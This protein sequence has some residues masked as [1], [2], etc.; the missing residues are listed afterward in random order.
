MQQTQGLEPFA[1]AS[2]ASAGWFPPTA[3][4]SSLSLPP[5]FLTSPE[6]ANLQLPISFSGCDLKKPVVTVGIELRKSF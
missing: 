4:C 6:E 2:S 5:P 1:P 3:C